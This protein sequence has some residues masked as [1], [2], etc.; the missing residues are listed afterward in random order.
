MPRKKR[1]T[2]KPKKSPGRPP[3]AKSKKINKM[4]AKLLPMYNSLS[5]KIKQK[6]PINKFTLAR[7]YVKIGLWKLSLE[8][9]DLVDDIQLQEWL[10]QGFKGQDEYY[11]PVKKGKRS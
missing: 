9:L 7:N 5:N 4:V 3:T 10:Q 2:D 6:Y 8:E 11:R 1:D